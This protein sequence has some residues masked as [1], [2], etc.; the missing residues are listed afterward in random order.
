MSHFSTRFLGVDF[1]DFS[2]ENLA[3]LAIFRNLPVIFFQKMIEKFVF[4]QNSTN[5]FKLP[6][7]SKK[8]IF[9]DFWPSLGHFSTIFWGVK[10]RDSAFWPCGTVESGE[11]IENRHF[12]F[13]MSFSRKTA[14]LK[15]FQN[16]QNCRNCR[17]KRFLVIWG[18]VMAVFRPYTRKMTKIWWF[19]WKIPFFAKIRR[20][21]HFL[22]P[23]QKKNVIF[24][25]F[26]H[27]LPFCRGL[28]EI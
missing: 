2:V 8:P 23:K 1:F 7:K 21:F 22:D 27:F 16:A 28:K 19:W 11:K 5:T 26:A 4:S 25:L 12:F 3:I 24:H 14:F 20:F 15:R 9:D 18:A 13:F 6:K 10:N 17:K